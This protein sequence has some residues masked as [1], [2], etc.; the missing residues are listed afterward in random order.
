M[1]LPPK[2]MLQVMFAMTKRA[3]ALYEKFQELFPQFSSEGQTIKDC[4]SNP[5]IIN[6]SFGIR[7]P[8]YLFVYR[9]DS[10]WELHYV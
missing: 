10:N 9:S 2:R 7:G 8:K 1:T 4:G 5:I 6:P 3:E